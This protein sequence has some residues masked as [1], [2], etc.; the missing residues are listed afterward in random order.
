MTTVLEMS[1]LFEG[2][3]SSAQLHI[4]V[5]FSLSSLMTL[6]SLECNEVTQGD[7]NVLLICC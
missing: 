1:H 4:H 7:F 3:I 2:Y 6:I 5:P